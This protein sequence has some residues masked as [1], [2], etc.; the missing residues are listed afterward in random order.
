MKTWESKER[1]KQIFGRSILN[2]YGARQ[3]E[4]PYREICL[5]FSRLEN[6]SRLRAVLCFQSK[7]SLLIS[8]QRAWCV[9]VKQVVYT[10]IGIS[11]GKIYSDVS[12]KEVH[13]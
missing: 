13:T 3:Q 12:K 9:Q 6:G 4:V 2:I 8:G 10:Y 1:Q 7:G 5:K 11:F